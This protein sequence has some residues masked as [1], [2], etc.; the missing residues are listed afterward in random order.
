MIITDL[1]KSIPDLSKITSLNFTTDSSVYPP[2]T[3][4]RRLLDKMPKVYRLELPYNYL[5]DLLKSPLIIQLLS[6]KIK[7]LYLIFDTD[8]PLLPDIIRILKIFSKDLNFLY[9]QIR[10]D[11]PAK[12]FSFILPSLFSGICKKLY[13]FRLRLRPKLRQQQQIFDEQFKLKLRNC[14]TAQL[15]K[16][17][18]KSGTMEYRIKDNELLIS[19]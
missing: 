16:S 13:G 2:T 19:F 8:P 7:T 18:A 15:E 1:I 3:L 9:F 11:F 5:L 14:L 4:A 12:I 6:K 10:M 17:K